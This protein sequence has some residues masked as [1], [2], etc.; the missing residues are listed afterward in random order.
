M[1]A[2]TQTIKTA[3]SIRMISNVPPDIEERSEILALMR[4]TKRGMCATEISEANFLP[5]QKTMEHLRELMASGNIVRVIRDG[6]LFHE[7][8]R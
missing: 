4:F 8:A 5:L 3:R 1:I 2:N 7:L 6:I